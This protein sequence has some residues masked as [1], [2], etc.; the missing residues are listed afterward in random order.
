MIKTVAIG[1]VIGSLTLKLGP[2]NCRLLSSTFERGITVSKW[3]QFFNFVFSV[4]SIY[5]VLNL[6]NKLR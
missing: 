2:V 6:N 3:I 4:Y 1:K 5:T